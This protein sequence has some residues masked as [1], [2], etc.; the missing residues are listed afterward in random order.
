MTRQQNLKK[1]AMHTWNIAAFIIK[2]KCLWSDYCRFNTST[3][4]PEE[5]D[6]NPP[7]FCD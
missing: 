1:A 5:V 6:I 3:M 4:V 7:W 2:I